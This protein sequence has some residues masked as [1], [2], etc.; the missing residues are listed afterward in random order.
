MNI[1]H[2]CSLTA[3][4]EIIPTDLL[5]PEKESGVLLFVTKQT[6]DT[7]LMK[8]QDKNIFQ[9]SSVSEVNDTLAEISHKGEREM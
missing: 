8:T 3:T 1:N 2:Y 7:A 4:Q 6:G 5:C 9:L